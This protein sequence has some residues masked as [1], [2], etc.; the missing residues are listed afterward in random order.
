MLWIAALTW[1]ITRET[2]VNTTAPTAGTIQNSTREPVASQQGWIVVDYRP[3]NT[4]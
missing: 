2:I 3:D 1:F 4:D